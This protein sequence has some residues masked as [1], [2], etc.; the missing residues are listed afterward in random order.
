M[1]GVSDA[2]G[3]SCCP[4]FE[5]T[6]HLKRLKCGHHGAKNTSSSKGKTRMASA[7]LTRPIRTGEKYSNTFLYFYADVQRMTNYSQD[8]LLFL[9]L[10]WQINIHAI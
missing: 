4:S 8:I 3:S 9:S 5:F 1:A 7:L 10:L 6:V 2:F